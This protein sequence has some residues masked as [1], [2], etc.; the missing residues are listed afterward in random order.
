MIIKEI[1]RQLKV[2]LL[3]ILLLF[4]VFSMGCKRSTKK[5]IDTVQDKPDIA[6]YINI[7]SSE[8]MEKE[9]P[10]DWIGSFK[11]VCETNLPEN[12]VI[13]VDISNAAA[14]FTTDEEYH[15]NTSQKIRLTGNEFFFTLPHQAYSGFI[16][17]VVLS[18]NQPESIL[19][20]FNINDEKL[21]QTEYLPIPIESKNETEIEFYKMY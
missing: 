15:F 6:Y 20:H 11:V 14:A 19:Q 21:F 8:M 10:E 7:I 3:Y 5:D 2:L 17:F 16:S 4:L 13:M 9:R 1:I 18:E 12:T